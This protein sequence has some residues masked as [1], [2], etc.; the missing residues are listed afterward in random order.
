MQKETTTAKMGK[1]II[2]LK[3]YNKWFY[4]LFIVLG[5]YMLLFSDDFMGGVANLGIALI[6]DPFNPYETWN[7]RPLYQRALLIVHVALV[8]GLL[9]YGWGF[10]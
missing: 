7:K 2:D 1:R 8:I 10:R 6:F 5:I 4:G 3:G 9:V